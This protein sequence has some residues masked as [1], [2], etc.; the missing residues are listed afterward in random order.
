MWLS[1]LPSQALPAGASQDRILRSFHKTTP[2]PGQVS[3]HDEKAVFTLRMYRECDNEGQVL[4]AGVNHEVCS[5]NAPYLFHLTAGDTHVEG[6]GWVQ[7]SAILTSVRMLK[8]HESMRN[9][10]M[11]PDDMQLVL[12]LFEEAVA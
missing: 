2:Y 9:W 10:K 4:P 1:Y 3:I 5:S 6:G 7:A 8:D 12:P 11:H